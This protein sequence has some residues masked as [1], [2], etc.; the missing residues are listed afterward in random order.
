[1]VPDEQVKDIALKRQFLERAKSLS[2]LS[3]AYRGQG[4]TQL[5]C[6]MLALGVRAEAEVFDIAY[7][8]RRG[9]QY[10]GALLAEPIGVYSLAHILAVHMAERTEQ[11][12]MARIAILRAFRD[13]AAAGEKW[14]VGDTGPLLAVDDRQT[15]FANLTGLKVHPKAAIEWLLSKPRRAHLVPDGLR[16]FLQSGGSPVVAARP[17]TEKE[18]ERFATSFINSEIAAGRHPTLAGLEAAA[19]KS[20]GGMC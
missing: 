8:E 19:K 14:F 1:M 13:A 16:A 10:W 2:S 3:E 12:D 7:G 6:D 18:A 11:L 20:S 4:M 17:L 15:D 9:R 5:L